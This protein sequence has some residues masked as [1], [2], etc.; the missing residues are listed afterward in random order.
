MSQDQFHWLVARSSDDLVLQSRQLF[1]KG[2]AKGGV[3]P[4]KTSAWIP[5]P[6]NPPKGAIASAHHVPG[7]SGGSM[8]FDISETFFDS[9]AEAEVWSKTGDGEEFLKNR[10]DAILIAFRK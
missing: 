5:G 7:V 8:H 9:A 2:V 3:L 4:T 10:K 1:E 6:S